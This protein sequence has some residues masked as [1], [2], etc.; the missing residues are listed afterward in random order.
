[1]KK[2]WKILSAVGVGLLIPL[3]VYAYTVNG[4]LSVSGNTFTE[5]TLSIGTGGV[6]I[7]D[8]ADGAMTI[9]G[10]GNGSDESITLNLDDTSNTAVLSSATGVDNLD[11]HTI[12]LRVYSNTGSNLVWSVDRAT[13]K[14]IGAPYKAGTYNI[15]LVRATTSVTGDSIG[16][17]CGGASCSATNPGFV[18]AP[19]TTAGALSIFAI[20]ADVT[21]NLTGA[22]WGEN[23]RGDLTGRIL[24]VTFVND[25]GTPRWCVA[26]TGNRQTVS[27][28][29]PN[30]T[31]ATA[32]DINTANEMLCNAAVSSATNTAF[33]IGYFRSNFDDTGGSSEDLNTIQSGVNDVVTGQS[34]DGIRQP[35]NTGGDSYFSANPVTRAYWTQNGRLVTAW[36]FTTSNG[37]SN[38]NQFQ[39]HAPVPGSFDDASAPLASYT[40]NGTF[41][42]GEGLV[43]IGDASSSFILST[44][45]GAAA[46]TNSGA[47]SANFTISYPVGQSA[48]Y[49]E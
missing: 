18:V 42:R 40:D 3:T 26:L 35:F 27:T 49:I 17:Q 10:A 39:L 38:S 24:R 15:N 21:I 11:L 19:S 46:W 1:M 2:Y 9:L 25:N 14:T 41:V 4:N 36:V 37:T 33:E 5:G 20:T 34:A 32:T 22:H 28:S 31:S 45:T 16:I 23:T 30:D 6:V 8:D 13:G 29:A 47:K 48:S 44:S 7:S 43:T 12:G